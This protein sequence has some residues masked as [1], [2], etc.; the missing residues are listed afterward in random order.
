[1]EKPVKLPV[2]PSKSVKS[3]QSEMVNFSGPVTISYKSPTK[4]VHEVSMTNVKPFFESMP[5]RIKRICNGIE[6]DGGAYLLA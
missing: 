2:L 6:Y 1:M 3:G 5:L 4:S